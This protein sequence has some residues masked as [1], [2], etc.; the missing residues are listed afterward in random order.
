MHTHTL[1]ASQFNVALLYESART[2]GLNQEIRTVQ[3][4]TWALLKRRL[5]NPQLRLKVRTPKMLGSEINL[6]LLFLLKLLRLVKMKLI[7]SGVASLVLL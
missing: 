2:L 1:F 5:E 7:F 4:L 3:Y 6:G